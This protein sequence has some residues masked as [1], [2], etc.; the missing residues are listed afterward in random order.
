MNILFLA[1]R[2]PYP[3]DKGD[4]IRSFNEIVYLSQNHNIYLATT[5]DCESDRMHV[6]KLEEYCKE[7]YALSFNRRI[8]LLKGLFLQKPFSISGFYD[9]SIQD[10]VNRTLKDKDIDVVIC[11]CS[12][13][14]E[15]IFSA[16]GYLENG[17]EGKTLIMDF[18]DLDSDKWLQYARYAKLPLSF[19]YRIENKRLFKYE[20]KINHAVHQSVFVSNREVKA[21]EEIYPGASNL[22]VIPN[23]VDYNYFSPP[24]AR[25]VDGNGKSFPRLVF[26]GVMDYFANEDG[27]KW[28]CDQIFPIIKA[29]FPLA[30][31]YIVG[32]R[33]TNLVWSLSEIDGVTVTG[34][35]D[36]IREYYWLADLCVIPLRIARGLQ[37]KVIEA[38]ATGNAVVATSNASDGIV[39]HDN[40]DIA[41][42]DGADSFAEKVI[43][44]LKD[45]HSRSEMG[46][47]AVENIRL[48]YSWEGNL[49]KFDELL[50][51]DI[52]ISLPKAASGASN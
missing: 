22:Q 31:F 29:E 17:L 2:I 27:V 13:M 14:A 52:D 7:V 40:Y 5:L 9:R 8:K 4:K 41:I 36:D 30:E 28:F 42:A 12:S 23:G 49:E 19:I 44:L 18:V 46:R 33:P 39:C 48:N 43:H 47:R 26:T 3:P 38:M 37:N 45:E 15:Y 35:V 51:A 6:P 16:P 24:P 11:F 20:T 34:Y 1:H 10:Y 32:N 21:L 50:N 25:V